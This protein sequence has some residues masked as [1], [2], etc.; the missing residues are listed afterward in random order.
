[1]Q[2]CRGTLCAAPPRAAPRR[3]APATRA[4]TPALRAS[5]QRPAARPAESEGEIGSRISASDACLAAARSRRHACSA[6]AAAGAGRTA[7]RQRAGCPGTCRAGGARTATEPRRATGRSAPRRQS[8]CAI[9]KRLWKGASDVPSSLAERSRY[10]WSY[11]ATT[12]AATCLFNARCARRAM[13]RLAAPC[14]PAAA[15]LRCRWAEP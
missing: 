13:V 2:R 12:R 3:R 5:Q 4:R 10:R 1:M 11:D 14:S 6:A 8:C 9:A 7:R 15:R